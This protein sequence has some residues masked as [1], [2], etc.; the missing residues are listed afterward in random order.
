[1]HV[2]LIGQVG[3]WR[4]VA[5]AAR[6]NKH[7][8]KGFG[9]LTVIGTAE[10]YIHKSG[11]SETVSVVRCD[12][13]NIKH[14]RNCS[15]TSGLTLSCGCLKRETTIANKWFVDSQRNDRQSDYDRNAARQDTPVMV[16]CI[17]NAEALMFIS[18]RR[19]CGKADQQTHAVWLAV[20]D[21]VSKVDPVLAS[22]CVPEC[23]YRGFCPE[24]K[25]CKYNYSVAQNMDIVEYRHV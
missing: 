20:I 18:R 23:V 9:R 2:E 12:C 7:I 14:V 19:L 15:L 6:T 11:R 22:C 17:I 16:T 8:G 13:G 10:P 5:D 21:A 24:F 4:A 3:S 1:M 25:P